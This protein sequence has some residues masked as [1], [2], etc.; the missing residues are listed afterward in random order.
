MSDLMVV[1]SSDP[2]EYSVTKTFSL[3]IKHVGMIRALA[4]QTGKSQAE[5]LREAIEM[6]YERVT[7][8][9]GQSGTR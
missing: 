9:T 8:E 1:P 6:L 7:G 4:V 3:K 5:L 2:E